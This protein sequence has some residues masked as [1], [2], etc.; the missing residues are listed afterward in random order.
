MGPHKQ[1]ARLDPDGLPY[2]GSIIWPKQSYYTTKDLLTG[3]YRQ[4]AL[5]GEEVAHIEQARS[6]AAWRVVH[7]LR[8]V[9]W[10]CVCPARARAGMSI[11]EVCRLACGTALLLLVLHARLSHCMPGCSTHARTHALR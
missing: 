6:A 5:K 11:S 8:A 9:W 7:C 1:A 3:R 4:H 2:V 10:R